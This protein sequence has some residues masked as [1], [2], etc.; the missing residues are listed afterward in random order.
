MDYTGFIIG[1]IIGTVLA[2]ACLLAKWA[3]GERRVRREFEA[4]IRRRYGG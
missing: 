1:G 2:N 4:E 3:I